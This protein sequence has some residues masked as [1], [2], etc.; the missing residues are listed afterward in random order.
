LSADTLCHQV[1]TPK[2]EMFQFVFWLPENFALKTFPNIKCSVAACCFERRFRLQRRD[3]H[4]FAP[5]S[6]N[7]WRIV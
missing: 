6:V 1:S 2:D 3:R 7:W 5:C 4:G